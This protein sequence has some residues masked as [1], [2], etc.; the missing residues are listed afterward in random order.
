MAEV[1]KAC[2]VATCAKRKA[3]QHPARLN[4]EEDS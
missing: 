3:S 1:E 4:A 2:V